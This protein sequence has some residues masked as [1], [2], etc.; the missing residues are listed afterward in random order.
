MTSTP[1]PLEAQ[2]MPIDIINALRHSRGEE[3]YAELISARISQELTFDTI[4]DLV[5]EDDVKNLHRLHVDTS[6]ERDAS[7]KNIQSTLNRVKSHGDLLGDKADE[8]RSTAYAELDTFLA[9]Q[10]K[11]SSIRSAMNTL[12]DVLDF[13]RRN[14]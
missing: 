11:V 1:S 14:A 6:A 9:L 5:T 2:M 7:Q 8:Y 3:V 13:R 4:K 10:D 12:K